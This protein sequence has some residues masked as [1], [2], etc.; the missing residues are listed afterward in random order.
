MGCVQGRPE[1][2]NSPP[3]GL[4]KLKQENGYITRRGSGNMDPRRSTGQRHLQEGPTGRRQPLIPR[5]KG[6]GGGSGGGGGGRF[7]G[8]E[9]ERA[10]NGSSGDVFGLGRGEEE[11]VDGWPK[12][13]VNNVPRHVLKGLVP[14]SADSYDKIDKVMKIIN[15]DHDIR[16]VMSFTPNRI[17]ICVIRCA[18]SGVDIG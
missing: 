1:S 18:H 5:G 8:A 7:G 4:D 2:M 17:R 13:L 14:K 10:G 6:G 12:W 16:H 3:K 15:N 11:T 9:V